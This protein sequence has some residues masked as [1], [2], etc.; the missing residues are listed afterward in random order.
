MNKSF[1]FVTALALSAAAFAGAN[2]DD[3]TFPL[4]ERGRESEM[5]GA[6]G[7]LTGAELVVASQLDPSQLTFDEI[8][9][10]ESRQQKKKALREAEA[11]LNELKISGAA[12]ESASMIAAEREVSAA[13]KAILEIPALNAKRTTLIK[14]VKWMGRSLLIA[15]ALG[16]WYVWQAMDRDPTFSPI[17]TYT[18]KRVLEPAFGGRKEAQSET[19]PAPGGH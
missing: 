3:E 4:K 14:S 17:A 19:P 1:L 10:F 2:K 9:I 12:P 11:K 6:H 8:A 16:R 18:L 7:M 13:R 5:A 15:D